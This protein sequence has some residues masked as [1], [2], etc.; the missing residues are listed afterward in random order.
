MNAIDHAALL[1]DA[2][3]LVMRKK[4]FCLLRLTD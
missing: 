4:Q 1:R 3:Q 2:L